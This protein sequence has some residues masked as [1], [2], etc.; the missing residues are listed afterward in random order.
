MTG[1]SKEENNEKKPV[2]RKITVNIKYLWT[3]QA[4]KFKD[5]ICSAFSE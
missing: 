1:R 5:A 3:K 2:E 4:E